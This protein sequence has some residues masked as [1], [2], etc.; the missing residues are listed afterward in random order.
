MAID[1]VSVLL[2]VTFSTFQLSLNIDKA[3]IKS[4]HILKLSVNEI[5]TI[6]IQ[7]CTSVNCVN[8][9]TVYIKIAK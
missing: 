8:P 3:K 4:Y 1:K 9:R 5:D 2:G 7:F 6:K